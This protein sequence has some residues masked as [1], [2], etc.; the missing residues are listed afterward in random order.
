MTKNLFP[1]S[2]LMKHQFL[3]IRVYIYSRIMLK[4]VNNVTFAMMRVK[5]FVSNPF[6]RHSL[7]KN[8]S[9]SIIFMESFMGNSVHET[10][11][12]LFENEQCYARRKYLYFFQKL[13]SSYRFC[14]CMGI[15]TPSHTSVTI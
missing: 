6:K 7:K 9:L 2:P 8:Y 1:F 11:H 10:K 15:R 3:S 13:S 12:F 5:S 14:S 4:N